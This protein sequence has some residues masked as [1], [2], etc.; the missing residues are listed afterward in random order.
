MNINII[1]K[2]ILKIN[3]KYYTNLSYFSLNKSYNFFNLSKSIN[4]FKIYIL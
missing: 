3:F 4:F 1:G 2:N